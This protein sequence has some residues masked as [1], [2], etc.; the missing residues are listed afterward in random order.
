MNKIALILAGG[1]GERMKES[2]PKQFLIL[3]NKPILMHTIKKF[4]DFDDIVVVINKSHFNFWKKLCVKYQFT[5]NHRLVAGGKTRFNSVKNGLNV[6]SDDCAV[7]IHDGVRPFVTKNLINKIISKVID[8]HE[9][10]GLIPTIP[11][12]DSVCIYKKKFQHIDRDNMFLI[13]TP[14]CFFSKSIKKAY[15]QKYQLS[16]TDDA[17]VFINNNGKVNILHGEETNIK[18]TTKGDLKLFPN[19]I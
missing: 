12:K 1:A 6:I 4:A 5:A 15:Q 16:F 14:Q 9:N 17:S 13:Q 10:I 8:G 11:I 18:I 7:A 19:L 3:D 2:V